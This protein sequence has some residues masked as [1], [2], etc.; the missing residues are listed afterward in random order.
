MIGDAM[1]TPTGSR[2]ARDSAVCGCVWNGPQLMA[3]F[4]AVSLVG[5]LVWVYGR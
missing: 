5:T 3:L 1:L 4:L 2:H